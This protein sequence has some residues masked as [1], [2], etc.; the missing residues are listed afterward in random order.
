MT[1]EKKAKWIYWTVTTPFVV[2]TMLAG[3]MFLAGLPS[4][5]EGNQQL[6]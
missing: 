1:S 4:N 5:V 6:A 3:L 2:T